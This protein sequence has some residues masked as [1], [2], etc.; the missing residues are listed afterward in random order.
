VLSTIIRS[1]EILR[2]VTLVTLCSSV[3]VRDVC[4]TPVQNS[5]H[6]AYFSLDFVRLATRRYMIRNCMVPSKIRL[7]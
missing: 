6:F 1:V 3:K 2:S 7:M 4:F 5:E